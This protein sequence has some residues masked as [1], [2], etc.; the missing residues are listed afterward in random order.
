MTDAPSFA[1]SADVRAVYDR[2]SRA[3]VGDTVTYKE[4]G[5]LVRRDVQDKDR[6]VLAS[7]LR[8]C[9]NDGIAFGTIMRVG[10]KRLGDV[11]IVK[12]AEGG[13]SRIRHVARK[14]AKRAMCVADF[15]K[16]PK[17]AKT[18]HNA[19]VSVYGA[20]AHLSTEKVAKKIEG[21]VTTS[22]QALALADTL[23]AFK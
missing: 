5:E 12:D 10:V 4:L 23:E 9:L 13:I 15:D 16:M 17:E 22:K 3:A 18:R 1:L 19:L 14:Y 20:I 21:K 7:A 2:L 8:K 6:H 11:E